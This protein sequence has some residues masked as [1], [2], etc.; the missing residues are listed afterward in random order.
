MVLD[1]ERGKLPPEISPRVGQDLQ[2]QTQSGQPVPAKVVE[3]NDEAI[4]VDAN[5]PLAGHEL[6]FDIELVEIVPSA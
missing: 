3:V 2:L 6:T 4:K 1:I 5:H